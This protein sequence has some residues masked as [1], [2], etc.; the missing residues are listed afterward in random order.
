M[1][2]CWLGS[3]PNCVCCI[4]SRETKM[5]CTHTRIQT[6]VPTQAS[7]HKHEVKRESY[8]LVCTKTDRNTYSQMHTNTHTQSTHTS[9]FKHV[10]YTNRKI[11]RQHLFPYFAYKIQTSTPARH[12]SEILYSFHLY[13]W[14]LERMR[15]RDLSSRWDSAQET[16]CQSLGK[17]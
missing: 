8:L 4:T 11:K 3:P 16:L 2:M 10:P 9:T 13:V 6:N 7:I 14:I 1:L 15:N 17:R 5:Q 12:Q